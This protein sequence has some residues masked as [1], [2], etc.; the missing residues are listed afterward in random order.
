MRKTIISL[1]LALGVGAAQADTLA[2]Q[3]NAPERYVV[4]KGDTLWG[5]SG[6]FL[7]QPWRW[8]E[9]WQLNRDEIKN[10]HWIYPGDVVVLD[11]SG[12]TPRLKLLKSDKVANRGVARLSPRVR[13]TPIDENGAA[14][15]I[16]YAAIEPF[17]NKPLVIDP[18][19]F[20]A[21]PRVAAGPDSR[22]FFA[23]GDRIYAVDLE[24]E[25]GDT[26]QAFR[27]GQKL[28]DPDDPDGKRVIGYQVDY[29]GDVRMEKSGDV[30]TLRVVSAREEIGVGSRLI[31]ATDAPFINYAPHAPAQQVNGRVISAYG[32]VAEAGQYTT[33]VINRGSEAGVDIGTVLNSYKR[34]RAIKKESGKEPTRYT[35]AE[36]SSNVFVYRVFPKFSYGL[37]LDSTLP[38]NVGDDV[39]S[40]S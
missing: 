6:H 30:A 5:I 39:K 3:G 8:P 40:P 38:V 10:P 9:I 20:K 13:S 26:W 21:A 12:D 31:R 36:K 34:E 4:V 24:G 17:L 23:A 25:A 2:L 19:S 37:L 35:P 32:G 18:A 11:R 28:V 27:P 7:K 1:L 14:P 29:L 15:S 16:P 22:V 33:I